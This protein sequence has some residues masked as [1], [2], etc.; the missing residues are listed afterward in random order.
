MGAREALGA[1]D[2]ELVALARGDGGVF[3]GEANVE[4]A[5]GEVRVLDVKVVGV[6][7]GTV[8]ED[9]DVDGACDGHVVSSVPDLTNFQPKRSLGL[10]LTLC[11]LVDRVGAVASECRVQFLPQYVEFVLQVDK[12]DICVACRSPRVTA[13]AGV[14]VVPAED[15]LLCPCLVAV[16]PA[17]GVESGRVDGVPEM[18]ADGLIGAVH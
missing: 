4:A 17:H 2:D 13:H 9:G 1:V 3:G 15:L 5:D 12:K 18:D 7:H 16:G 11:P 10:S 6:A 8:L 14:A